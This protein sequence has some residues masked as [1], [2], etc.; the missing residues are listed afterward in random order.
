[1]PTRAGKL[2][3]LDTGGAKPV[4]LMTPDGPCVIEHHRELIK[5]LSRHFRVVCFDMPGMGFSFPDWRFHFGREETTNAIVELLDGLSISRVIVAFSCA[6]G[7]TA[8]SLAK[9]HPQRVSHLVLAQTPS[10]DAMKKWADRNIPS[11]LLVPYFGQIAGKV[12]A[13]Y[14]ATHWFNLCLPKN[15]LHKAKL[16]EEARVA[17]D[18]GGCFCLASVVQGLKNSS[19]EDLLGVDCPTMMIHGDSD[20]SHRH[21]DFH[22][23]TGTIPNAEIIRFDNCGHFPSLERC[24]DYVRLLHRFVQTK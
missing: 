8:M 11:I 9:Q 16:A 10:Q 1:M 7:L 13:K 5:Q 6:N 12:G 18:T 17:V 19:D 20:R 2:R 14:L 24:A 21:T 3:F 4:I 22:S 15:S 23:L